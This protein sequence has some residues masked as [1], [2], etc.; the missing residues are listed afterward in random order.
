MRRE[1]PEPVDE[2]TDGSEEWRPNEQEGVQGQREHKVLHER[3]I[4]HHYTKENNGNCTM[5]NSTKGKSSQIITT[6]DN[7]RQSS[8][9]T[10][11]A[12][13]TTTNPTKRKSRAM[14]MTTID[15]SRKG[16]TTTTTATPTTTTTGKT[17]R[18]TYASMSMSVSSSCQEGRT[19]MSKRMVGAVM[20]PGN[21]MDFGDWGPYEQC[22]SGTYAQAFQ[23][24]VE[25][26][27]GL[28]GDD[29]ALNGIRLYCQPPNS[30]SLVTA[31]ITSS[32][33]CWGTWREVQ[34]CEAGEFLVGLALRVEEY[35]GLADDTA[36]TDLVMLCDGGMSLE[37][38]GICWGA[39]SVWH[40][41]PP[42]FAICGLKT[43]V[44][45][46]A[47]LMGDNTALNNVIMY[48]CKMTP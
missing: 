33:Q 28:F 11:T 6:I 44:E 32:V 3:R 29:T 25:E 37:G 4:S 42:D 34:W 21:G 30:A 12:T 9:T 20:D 48:C 18:S 23:I 2:M 16:F 38:G 27:L 46:N 47:G 45:Q 36:A 19:T 26:P 35:Q 31:S 40:I 22:P 1:V 10:T 7:S 14:M 8:T 17:R 41:C 43:R 39:L 15:S 24:R 5:K 13:P